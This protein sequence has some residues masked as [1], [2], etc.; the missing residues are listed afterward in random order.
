MRQLE[1]KG[2]MDQWMLQRFKS[3]IADQMPTKHDNIVF[4]RLAPEQEEVYMRVLDSPD[5]QQLLHKDDPCISCGSG[6][7]TCKCHSLDMDGV[8][9]KWKH[10]DGEACPACPSCILMPALIQLNKIANHLELL[11]PEKGASD[12]FYQKQADFARMAHGDPSMS[13]AR[14]RNFWNQSHSATCGKMQALEKLLSS[15][16]AKGSK[17]LLF[18]YSTQMLDILEDFVSRK[19]YTS[20]RL[21]GSTSTKNRGERVNR[22]NTSKS[23]FIFLLSTKAG[24]LGLN[25]VSANRVVIF[26]PNWNPAW[27]MQAQ[28]RAYRIGQRQNV[29]VYRL[30]SSNTIEEKVY[31]RQLYKQGQEGLVLHQRDET[32]YFEGVM[33]DR[34][35]QGDLFGIKNLL[36]FERGESSQTLQKSGTRSI[37]SDGR[38]AFEHESDEEGDDVD[39][40]SNFVIRRTA[41]PRAGEADDDADE[42]DLDVKDLGAEAGVEWLLKK[43]EPKTSTSK[44]TRED[45]EVEGDTGE[46]ES[47]E[48]MADVLRRSGA[49]HTHLNSKVLGGAAIDTLRK[50]GGASERGDEPAAPKLESGSGSKPPAPAA[51]GGRKAPKHV[52][53]HLP[54]CVADCIGDCRTYEDYIRRLHRD[55]AFASRTEY[56]CRVLGLGE[57]LC[58]AVKEME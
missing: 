20:L 12:E 26:D 42:A 58:A 27:D 6:M 55:V 53:G 49:V 40:G 46:G 35:Q 23:I 22:F 25:L 14:D 54:T 34:R 50:P 15:W 19:G 29:E 30:I 33:G 47:E 44:R 7:P 31:Q 28:D 2:L 4:C 57:E 41:R 51:T 38:T 48:P 18:S 37:I 21:D 17:V 45:E 16:K 24:G 11:K 3:I 9:A 52:E 13:V 8:L 36:L 32:R 43:C 10:P 1:L 39:G 56:C 5:Y